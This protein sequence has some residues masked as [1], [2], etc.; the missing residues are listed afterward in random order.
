MPP[1]PK[2]EAG[3]EVPSTSR[4]PANTERKRKG[5]ANGSS[6]AASKAGLVAITESDIAVA[7]RRLAR[8]EPRFRPVLKKYGLPPLWP[9]EP[10]FATLI[11]IILEQQVSM[12]SAQAAFERLQATLG[13]VTPEA[14]LGLDDAQLKTIGFSR[15]KMR[16][17][18]ELAR[19]VLDGSLDLN[20]L[21]VMEDEAVRSALTRLPG[22]GDW[23]VDVYLLMVLLRADAFPKGDLALLIAAHR[24]FGLTTR[25]TPAEAELMA[26]AWRPYRGVAT[27][28]L[29]HFYLSE[30]R[31]GPS[32]TEG[33]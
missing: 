5:A 16:Y 9:R 21:H 11:F 23:T 1:K 4:A 28:I 2:T 8:R 31:A 10:G 25:P 14:F 30:R 15:Q 32:R 6:G 3:R 33:S 13:V 19:V 29:W 26:E 22:I 12:Q 18:R 20:A 17:G 27:R 24:L 7:A